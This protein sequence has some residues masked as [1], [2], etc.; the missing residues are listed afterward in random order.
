MVIFKNFEDKSALG[1]LL[2]F[3]L[4]PL[5]YARLIDIFVIIPYNIVLKKQMLILSPDEWEEEP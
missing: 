3:A 5:L 4:L 1:Y 2:W